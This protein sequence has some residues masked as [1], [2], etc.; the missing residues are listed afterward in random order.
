MNYYIGSIM[1]G[2]E[3]QL[4]SSLLDLLLGSVRVGLPQYS[5]VMGLHKAG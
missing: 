4:T 3:G 1:V 5:F 2:S